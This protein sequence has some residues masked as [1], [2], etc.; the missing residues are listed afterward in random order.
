MY[1]SDLSPQDEC[2]LLPSPIFY[3]HYFLRLESFLAFYLPNAPRCPLPSPSPHPLLPQLSS[4]LLQSRASLV[5]H[6]PQME[7]KE[8]PQIC[9]LL[10]LAQVLQHLRFVNVWWLPVRFRALGGSQDTD[11]SPGPATQLLCD[12]R[13]VS[14]PP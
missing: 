8:A 2:F 11:P 7:P 13:Q 1:V 5:S 10:D 6:W 14:C 4:E 3:S 12:L 9:C